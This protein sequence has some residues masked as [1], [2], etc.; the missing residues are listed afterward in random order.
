[1]LLG[2][3]MAI[4]GYCPGTSAVGLF[5]GRVD[6]AF[7]MLGIIFGSAIFASLSDRLSEFYY[8]AKGPP[9]QTL[10]QLLHI[11]AWLVIALLAV[12]ALGGLLLG[13]KIERSAGGALSAEQ[14]C[15]TDVDG[16]KAHDDTHARRGR[17]I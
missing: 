14:V 9:A 10:N 6:G 4:G 11:P 1:M 12:L 16:R 7:F 2:A 5:S 13:T 15:G 8:A 3:G 17:T